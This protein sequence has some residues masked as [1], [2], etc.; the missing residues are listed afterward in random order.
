MCEGKGEE[1]VGDLRR[2]ST[3]RFRL[4]RMRESGDGWQDLVREI[5][6]EN[7]RRFNGPWGSIRCWAGLAARLTSPLFFYS[8]FY[9]ILFSLF[10]FISFAFNLQMRSNQLVDL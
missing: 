2:G 10:F 8:F 4:E 7:R 9:S 6:G 1:E 5:V 3:W